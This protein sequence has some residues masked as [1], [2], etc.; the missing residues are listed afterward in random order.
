MTKSDLLESTVVD[1]VTKWGP[2]DFVPLAVEVA[3]ACKVP[4]QKVEWVIRVLLQEQVLAQDEQ[5]RIVHG[6]SPSRD[7]PRAR[8]ATA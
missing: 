3:R 5:F 2:I 7:A 4:L 8:S 1:H 6:E